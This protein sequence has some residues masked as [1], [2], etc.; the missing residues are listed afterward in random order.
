MRDLTRLKDFLRAGLAREE[1]GVDGDG[2]PVM[3]GRGRR[4]RIKTRIVTDDD[5]GRVIDLHAMRTTLGTN[6][7]RTGIAPQLAQRIMRHSDYRTTLKH[8]TVLGLADTSR[9]INQL[10]D[11]KDVAA[12]RAVAT[13]TDGRGSTD[14]QQNDPQLYPQQLGRETVQNGAK[15]CESGGQ[16]SRTPQSPNPLEIA[17][18]N[19]T[20]QSNATPNQKAGER[21]RTVDVQLGK[22]AFYH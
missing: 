21:I 2:E 19:D 17:A 18:L 16:R 5:E 20:L 1:I 22:L 9:A 7:A 8:Y 12:A 11:V 14:L 15:Q 6:L 4:R 10:P 13:G 3:V